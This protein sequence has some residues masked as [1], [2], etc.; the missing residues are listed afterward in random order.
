[1]ANLKEVK[2]AYNIAK[3]F[4]KNSKISVLHCVSSYLLIS[5]IAIYLLLNF[6]KRIK[7]FSRMVR[8]YGR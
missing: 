8:S 2:R 6:K 7:M 1:M 5:E 4:N 3:K